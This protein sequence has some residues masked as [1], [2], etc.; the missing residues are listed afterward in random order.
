MKSGRHWNF[1]H[2]PCFLKTCIHQQHLCFPERQNVNRVA[3]TAEDCSPDGVDDQWSFSLMLWSWP[4]S[5]SRLTGAPFLVFFFLSFDSNPVVPAF[6]CPSAPSSTSP[7]GTLAFLVHFNC[8][9]PMATVFIFCHSPHCP[10]LSPLPPPSPLAGCSSACIVLQ[11]APALSAI[12][13]PG[14]QTLA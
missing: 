3:L 8:H 13:G 9:D 11:L 1:I 4:L 6:L 2:F 14:E 12:R 5:Y 7:S 10:F